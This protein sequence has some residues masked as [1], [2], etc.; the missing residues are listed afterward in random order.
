MAFYDTVDSVRKH[1]LGTEKKDIAGNTYRYLL[2]VASTAIGTW[3]VYDEAGVTTRMVT[4]STGP[5][6]I[7]KAAVVANKWGWYLVDGVGNGLALTAFADNG[8]VNATATDGSID[9]NSVAAAA[10]LQVFCAIGRSAVNET[11]L[12]ASFQI[13]H[14]YKSLALL[15]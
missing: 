3:V 6:A 15:D 13:W 14:P 8:T 12:L 10:E 7:A 1:R 11:T 5:V 2:G 9:D 4:T